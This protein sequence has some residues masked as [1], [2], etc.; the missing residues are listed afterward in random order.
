M[1]ALGTK[2][3]FTWSALSRSQERKSLSERFGAFRDPVLGCFPGGHGPRWSP[4]LNS[5]RLKVGSY[6]PNA[7]PST[8]PAFF[9]PIFYSWHFTDES[10]KAKQGYIIC[11]RVRVW[12]WL[13]HTLNQVWIPVDPTQLPL[14]QGLFNLADHKNDL[15]LFDNRV[16]GPPQA[17]WI[18][19]STVAAQWNHLEALGNTHAWVPPPGMLS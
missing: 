6:V 13:S 18:R 19:L 11:P 1:E 17:F 14:C 15:G 4:F 12:K 8:L 2:S 3:G 10:T 9:L 5:Q 16:L 7:A